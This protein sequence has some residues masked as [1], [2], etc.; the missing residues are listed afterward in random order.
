MLTSNPFKQ[1]NFKTK[2]FIVAFAIISFCCALYASFSCQW[3]EFIKPDY[4]TGFWSFLP[5]DLSTVHSVGLFGYQ[6]VAEEGEKQ[7]DVQCKQ[8]GSF[9]VPDTWWFLGP[10]LVFALTMIAIPIE[11]GFLVA[12]FNQKPSAFCAFLAAALQGICLVCSYA[13]CSEPIGTCPALYGSWII[14]PGIFFHILA[15]VVAVFVMEKPDDDKDK[16]D[17]D[18][19]R[20]SSNSHEVPSKVSLDER[21]ADASSIDEETGDRVLY[22]EELLGM[23]DPVATNNVRQYALAIDEVKALFRRNPPCPDENESTTDFASNDEED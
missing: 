15:F 12:G 21:P 10:Q 17:K 9:I 18:E 23:K 16:D 11:L 14:L 8:Y 19:S 7:W 5:E 3:H 2:A 6:P 22:A 20:D 13:W 1:L 4:D